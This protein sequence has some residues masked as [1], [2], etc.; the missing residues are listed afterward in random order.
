MTAAE[1]ELARDV[2][3]LLDVRRRTFWPSGPVWCV[4]SCIP[5]IFLRDR[6]PPAAPLATL[7][8]PP[9]PRPPAWICALTTT[10]SFSVSAISSFAAAS[11]SL[12]LSTGVPLGIGTPNFLRISF[13]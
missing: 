4:M 10:N 9:L 3:P 1:V 12:K 5:R 8:P 11:T 6:A 2:E 13:A 7:T